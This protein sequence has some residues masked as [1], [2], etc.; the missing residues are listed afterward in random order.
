QGGQPGDWNLSNLI[1]GA[2]G[3]LGVL[4]EAKLRLVPSPKATALCIVHFDDLLAALRAVPE[5]L[6][7]G[8][9]AVELLDEVVLEAARTNRA[10]AEMAD[11]LIGS[12]KAVQIV[13]VFGE[14]E[15]DAADRIHAVARELE[16]RGIGSHW[17]IRTDAAGIRR[18][19]EVRKL[20][21]GL[22]SNLEGKRKG[23]AV[24]EDACV[25]V[26]VLADYIAQVL[27]ICRRLEI[28]VS[29]YA[30]ASVGVLHVRPLLDLH[31]PADVRL[32]KQLSDEC[33]DLVVSYGGSWSSEHGDGMLRGEYVPRFFG[34]TLYQ[35]FR[36]VKRLF[37]PAGVMNPGKIVDAPPM[38][39]NLRYGPEY[40]PSERSS[41][42]HYRD[43]DGV[44]GAVEQCNGVGACRKIGTG[45]MCPSYMATRDEEHSTR[46]RA[47]ALRM[48]MS[49]QL[50][51]NAI[52]SDRMLEVLELC[53]ACKACKSECPNA[54]DMSRL[55]A[56]VLQWRYHERGT[57]WGAWFLA[58]MPD[59]LK[60]AAGPWSGIVNWAQRRGVFRRGLEWLTGIDHRRP[61]PPVARRTLSTW[62]ADRNAKA[63]KPTAWAAPSRQRVAVL[64]DTFT[65]YLEPE[66]GI[67]AIELLEGCGFEVLLAEV[68]CCQRPAISKG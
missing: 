42:F 41:R 1:V 3:T 58:G 12:P 44:V 32:M 24:V 13:E 59:A 53:L 62:F 18:V 9:S 21:L 67:A 11:F 5:M 26:A 43:Q 7:L 48:A 10:T 6:E 39:S 64:C 20:G 19:W 36:E 35:A 49:G 33:F 38:T 66:V 34:P 16:R 25:P 22:I 47:N 27:A 2:E 57:P 46:G 55:K 61:L 23:I 63:R 15:T 65:N 8:P 51:P 45:T 37:D 30:H 68:G 31:D 40:R 17:P 52:T 29:M 54:V 60:R 28:P 14:S 4:L 50:G 56:D